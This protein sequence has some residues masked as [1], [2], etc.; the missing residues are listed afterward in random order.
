[1]RCAVCDA[2]LFTWQN[3]RELCRPCF[4]AFATARAQVDWWMHFSE[5]FIAE[6]KAQPYL[7]A[8]G[9]RH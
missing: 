9:T 5:R 6:L 7:W 4:T 1:M 3:E 2:L 8:D